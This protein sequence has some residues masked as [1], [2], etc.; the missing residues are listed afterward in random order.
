[1]IKTEILKLSADNQD[2]PLL[3][4]AAE[5]INRGGV[6][7][8]PTETVYALGADAMNER[9]VQK[10]F[11][12]KKRMSGKPVA[13]FLPKLQDL[14]R[15]VKEITPSASRLIKEFWPGPLTLIFKSK[16]GQ[17]TY[18]TGKREK[19][20]VRVSSSKFVHALLKL[21]RAP[22][23][24]TSANLSGKLEPVSAE[25]VLSYF[26]GKIDLVINGGHQYSAIPSSVVDVSEE[27]PIL[28]REGRISYEKLKKVVPEL[29]RK[30]SR[31]V[32]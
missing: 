30:K 14:K 4:R 26:Y 7:A 23:T 20:G 24:A 29:K 15:F 32:S 22:L 21:T 16:P 31:A 6:I 9:A 19:L 1:M 3:Q 28:L 11:H 8:F 12:L 27:M 2:K 17:M 13:I 10:V 25:Q 18:L 5:I